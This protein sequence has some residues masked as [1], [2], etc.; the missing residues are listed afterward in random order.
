MRI[1]RPL[2]QRSRGPLGAVENPKVRMIL[3]ILCARLA[4][5]INQLVCFGNEVTIAEQTKFEQILRQY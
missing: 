4:L 3:I 5:D 1:G 2:G